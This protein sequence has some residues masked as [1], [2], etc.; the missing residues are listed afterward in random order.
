VIRIRRPFLKSKPGRALT[1]A[2][3]LF[4]Y[5]PFGEMFGF[6]ALPFYFFP[7][8]AAIVGMYIFIAEGGKK[9]FYRKITF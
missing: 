3:L 2:T 9:I 8:L 6:Q 7:L 1:R 5:T 4:P